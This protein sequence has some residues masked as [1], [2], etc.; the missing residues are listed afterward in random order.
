[1]EGAT[2]HMAGNQQQCPRCGNLAAVSDGIYRQ[3]GGAVE[4]VG[5]PGMTL[6]VLKSVGVLIE[7]ANKGQITVEAATAEAAK[8]NPELA[9]MINQ[10]LSLGIAFVMMMLLALQIYLAEQDGEQE[11][12]DRQQQLTQMERM[13]EAMERASQSEETT[14]SYQVR[15][16]RQKGA[17]RGAANKNRKER[18]AEAARNRN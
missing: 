17:N 15:S 8:I 13:A 4:I 2:L 1:M 7:R 14:R 18:R 11:A 10:W 5:A 3:I 12:L 9:S 6:A 16:P